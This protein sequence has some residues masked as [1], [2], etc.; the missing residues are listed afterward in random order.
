M[1][2]DC[3]PD[4]QNRLMVMPAVVIGSRESTTAR[5]ARLPS[6]SPVWLAAPT[7]TSSTSSGATF[8]FRSSSVSMQCASMSSERVRL[9]LP[10][11]D[12]ASPVR[13]LSTTTTSLAAIWLFPLE[14]CCEYPCD[15][16][17][18]PSRRG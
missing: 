16:Q 13:M 11:C 7:T 12:L 17:N 4:E 5:R 8:G 9:K 3:R 18:R 10:R 15:R 6:C 14:G 1:A 2:M